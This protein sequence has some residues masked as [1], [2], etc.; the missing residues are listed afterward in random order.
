MLENSGKT[1]GFLNAKIGQDK[2]HI[3]A[4]RI[5]YTAIS[6]FFKPFSATAEGL[7]VFFVVLSDCWN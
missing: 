1:S 2:L 3:I 7:A 5:E 4:I 6:V